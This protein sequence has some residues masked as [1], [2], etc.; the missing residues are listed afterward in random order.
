MMIIP[1]HYL[2]YALMVCFSVSEYITTELCVNF[3]KL[4]INEFR[5]EFFC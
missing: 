4:L 3:I 1:N 2:C 5:T